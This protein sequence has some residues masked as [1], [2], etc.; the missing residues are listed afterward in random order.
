MPI[1]SKDALI[2]RTVA[3]SADVLGS[4]SPVAVLASVTPAQTGNLMDKAKHWIADRQRLLRVRFEVDVLNLAH[5]S[6]LV[7]RFLRDKTDLGLGAGQ[8]R[9]P[10]EILLGAEGVGPDLAHSR[11]AK[12]VAE[13]QTINRTGG[14]SNSFIF[15][16]RQGARRRKP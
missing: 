13:D 11:R 14:H 9:L 15:L 12:D 5:T 4:G 2:C 8:R 6:D 10:V 3:E 7:G 1:K 16:L